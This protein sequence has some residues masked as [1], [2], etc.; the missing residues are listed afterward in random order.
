MTPDEVVAAGA[1][2]R[3]LH[4]LAQRPGRHRWSSS[5][6]TRHCTTKDARR[7]PTAHRRTCSP[8]TSPAATA[9]T[10]SPNGRPVPVAVSPRPAR[11][12]AAHA[13]RRSAD[14]VPPPDEG[15]VKAARPRRRC[16]AT[17]RS[18]TCTRPS[19]SWGGWSL[20]A[21]AARPAR[22][23]PTRRSTTGRHRP[24]VGPGRAAGHRVPRR[25]P[26]RCRGCA[27]ARTYRLRARLVDL[28]GNSV[29]PRTTIDPQHVSD[30]ET[31]FRWEPVPSPAV[32]PR[33]AVRRGRVAAAH[34]DPQ[35]ARRHDRRT[36]SRC[37]G[38]SSL[39]G[40]DAPAPRTASTTSAGSPR[41]RR[42][43]R[44]PSSTACSTRDRRRRTAEPRIDEAF[45]RRR[46]EVGHVPAAGGRARSSFNPV[47]RHA[48]RP[49]RV[50]AWR[51]AA[52]GRVRVHR[53][54]RPARLPYLPDV[55][56]R[57]V[58]F[59]SLPNDTPPNTPTRTVVDVAGRRH[60]WYDRQPIRIRIEDGPARRARRRRPAPWSAADCDAATRLLTVFV[61]QAEIVT[62][63][64]SSFLDMDPVTAPTIQRHDGA[65]ATSPARPQPGAGR[66]RSA[67]R[68][69]MLTPSQSSCF[70]HAVE[71]PLL[72]PVVDVDATR[73]AAQPRRDVLRA[74]RHR[75]TTTRRA[76]AGST[77]RRP[78]PSSSTTSPSDLP[79]DGVDGRPLRARARARRRLLSS[80]RRGR[81]PDRL[82][83]TSARSR[84]SRRST[85]CGTSS[86]TP[87]TV[88]SRYHADATTRFREYFPPE[89]VE[90]VDPRHGERFILHAGP[91]KRA[92]RA[93]LAPAGA[94][95]RAVHHPDVHVGGGD[96][97]ADCSRS[98]SWRPRRVYAAGGTLRGG[99]GI[100]GVS[101]P[102]PA[103][104]PADAAR[105][106]PA[107]VSTPRL[108][109]VR[110]RRTARRRAQGPTVAHVADRHRG[111][112]GGD[113]AAV[114]ERRPGRRRGSS[115]AAP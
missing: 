11:Y 115:I 71:K 75:S 81:L 103:D 2:R 109:L 45:D 30:P 105:R 113:A 60:R 97:D 104:V 42:R 28:A 14:P 84:A 88:A 79:E 95:R 54:R 51:S 29:R 77:S 106:R 49:E 101:T 91:E 17:T 36:T 61:P 56:S 31:F 23:C 1:A 12:V 5:S 26:G 35:H 7:R 107:R 111:R 39:A 6:T 8:K 46:R 33:R 87:S 102:H 43:S 73:H 24:M 112:H 68:A 99:T 20:V 93:E 37:R 19:F 38:S 53:H 21:E 55:A 15:Y 78:G 3:R 98:S 63:R 41:R 92:A 50:T 72:A 82:A 18:C 32:I 34:G 64:L 52:A 62:V 65:S 66:R 59:T 70:V 83:T 108:V 96:A 58:A 85:S 16:P 74:R 90:G 94:A 114:A 67:G 40:H 10:S 89:I 86:A 25:R 100:G 76:P 110:R 57:G 27:T 47:R 22:R 4:G 13:E 69:W 80:T 48:H 9:S 44:W